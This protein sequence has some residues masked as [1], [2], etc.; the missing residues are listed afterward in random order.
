AVPRAELPIIGV[1]AP[2]DEPPHPAL[3]WIGAPDVLED[4]R[5]SPDGR[6][7]TVGER[8]M[9][10]ALTPRIPTNLSYPDHTTA[11]FFSQRS[12]R[13]R[14]A[15]GEAD[16]A[17]FVART[18]WPED[19]RIDSQALTLEPLVKNEKLST[20]IE[21]QTGAGDTAFP[22]RLLFQR[23]PGAP[24]RWY[25]KPVLAMVL[26]GAQGDDDGSLAGH[27]GVATGYFGPRGE[28]QDWIVDNFYPLRDVSSKGIIPASV[29]MDNYLLDF[30]SGQLY[31]R[32]GYM[33]VAVLRR[34]E[35]ASAIHQ[36]LHQTMLAFYCREFTFDQASFNSTAMTMDPIRAVGWR[37]PHTG[38]T[39]RFLALL[40][41]PIAAVAQLSPQ[42]GRTAFNAFRQE[43]SRLLPRV[44]FEVA[45][46]DLLHLVGSRPDPEELTEFEQ[47]LVEDVEAV[48]FV[49]LPQIP[50]ERRVGTF[51]PRS[52]FTY[53][54]RIFV[55][56]T[57]FET[58]PDTGERELPQ[59]LEDAC[60]ITVP[61]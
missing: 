25:G 26:S 42:S 20:L 5:L 48:L 1:D 16:P 4:A 7:L 34:P 53:G 17:G 13:A 28:W 3:L 54:A 51:P 39:S 18:L 31:Y 21:A 60:D 58:A 2:A 29:P 49:R 11:R 30:N 24:P 27:L 47:R 57:E 61:F 45:G 9:S 44:A 32:P 41:A 22:A 23:D 15:P 19:A 10:L 56:P 14:G 36:A 38:P 37:I 35:V 59:A 50:S 33:L 8:S 46:H 40:A 6:T 43:T 52:L 12:S 55:D